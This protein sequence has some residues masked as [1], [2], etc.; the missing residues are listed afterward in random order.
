MTTT[1]TA[2]SDGPVAGTTAE[3]PDW[4]TLAGAGVLFGVE[5]RVVAVDEVLPDDD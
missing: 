5:V 2:M 4:A 3:G 1:E